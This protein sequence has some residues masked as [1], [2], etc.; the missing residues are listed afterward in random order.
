M[1]KQDEDF[2]RGKE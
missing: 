1:I 2:P